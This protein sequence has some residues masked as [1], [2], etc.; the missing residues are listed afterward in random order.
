MVLLCITAQGQEMTVTGKLVRVMAVG[1]ESTGRA[2][3][4]ESS[5]IE[6]DFRVRIQFE[7]LANKTV[8]ATGTLSRRHGV[9]TGDRSVLEISSMKEVEA[10]FRMIRRRS[11]F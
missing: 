2:I 1:G 9:E 7:E 8:S 6:M 11:R 5:R 4:R 3:E 10:K